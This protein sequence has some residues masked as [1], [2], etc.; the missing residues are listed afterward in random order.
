[1]LRD[2]RSVRVSPPPVSIR[3]LMSDHTISNTNKYK[4]YGLI[5]T[6]LA[7]VFSLII[8]CS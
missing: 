3:L 8:M 5:R 4:K 1:M 7:A 6:S 2:S